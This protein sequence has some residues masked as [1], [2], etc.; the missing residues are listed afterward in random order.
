MELK[1]EGIVLCL[2]GPA[3][4]GKTSLGAELVER[5]KGSISYSISATTRQARAGE[6]DG[7][8]YH[9]LPREDFLARKERGEFFETEEVHGNLYGTLLETVQSSMVQGKDLLL[10][11]DIKGALVFKHKLPLNTVIVFLSPP[12]REVL[13]ERI[14]GRG[15][16]AEE[17]LNRRLET[18]HAEFARFYEHSK[19]GGMID[20]LIV[21]AGREESMQQLSA[22][23]AAERLRASRV[24]LD[25]KKHLFS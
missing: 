8:H 23:L 21:N 25:F 6:Q 10:D 4:S 1:K 16:I 19:F 20:Y 22:I 13:I 11:V 2:V 3:G 5:H 7:V 9:F 17:E 24:S 14:K 12:S 15:G 18:A